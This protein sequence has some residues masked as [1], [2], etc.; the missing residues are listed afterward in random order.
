MQDAYELAAKIFNS[1]V[2]PYLTLCIHFK[3]RNQDVD[4]LPHKYSAQGSFD[5]LVVYVPVSNI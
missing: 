4:S 2:E 1:T 3:L 5:V